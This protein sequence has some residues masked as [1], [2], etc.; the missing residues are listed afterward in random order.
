MPTDHFKP[1]PRDAALEALINGINHTLHIYAGGFC[2][3]CGAAGSGESDCDHAPN[4]PWFAALA[5]IDAAP[6]ATDRRFP[7]MT[8]R[9][10]RGQPARFPNAPGHILWSVIEHHEAQ[11][12]RNHSQTLERLAERGG[13]DPLEALAVMTNERAYDLEKRNMSDDEITER[14]WAAIHEQTRLAAP[15]ATPAPRPDTGKL[16]EAV[17]EGA[18]VRLIAAE[19]QRQ[20]SAEGWTP[21]HDDTHDK[22]EMAAAAACYLTGDRNDRMIHPHDA[23]GDDRG[24]R[25]WP[26]PPENWPWDWSWWKPKDRLRNLV[27]AGALIA[28]EIDR[29]Q[30]AESRQ[31]ITPPD[32]PGEGADCPEC[33]GVGRVLWAPSGMLQGD[34]QCPSCN[35]T[36]KAAGSG[37]GVGE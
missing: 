15:P 7:I 9:S 16:A 8:V 3:L 30:R 24:A 12:Q 37:E 26:R 34:K 22:G 19:R 11:A 32:P 28:A 4:C 13:L 1:D 29:L 36:G 10:R 25:T 33:K 31:P 27:R 20:Q 18:G 6:P 5:A 2:N 17:G 21:E 14:L 35:G 23:M